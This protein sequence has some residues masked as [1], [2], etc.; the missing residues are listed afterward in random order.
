MIAGPSVIPMYRHGD[1]RNIPRPHHESDCA[2]SGA[3]PADAAPPRVLT[4]KATERLALLNAAMR[5]LR[6]MGIRVVAHSVA[7]EPFA[8][9]DPSIRIQRDPQVSLAALLDAA[10]SRNFWYD[11]PGHVTV[12]CVFEGVVV[13]WEEQR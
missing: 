2:W 3:N 7:G 12:S 4:R 9:G 1:G 10:G 5:R 13:I 6:A 8:C 11:T